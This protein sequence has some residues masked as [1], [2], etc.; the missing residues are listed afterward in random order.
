MSA[1]G[2]TLIKSRWAAIGAAVAVSLG[3][4][5]IGLTQAAVSSG[6]KPVFVPIE[7]CRLVDTR[8]SV[9]PRTAPLGA[10]EIFTQQITGSVGNCA[11]IP[12]EAVAAA[13]NVTS[14]QGTAQSF[15]TVYPGDAAAV[16]D[17]SNLNWRGGDPPKP[18]KVDVKLG[19]AGNV[20][21][22]NSVGTVHVAAD[23]VGYYIDHNHDDRYAPKLE[24][25]SGQ[26]E[27][28]YPADSSFMLVGDSYPQ[29]LP[30]GTDRPTIERVT[31]PT[32]TANCPA[33]GEAATAGV[34][35]VYEYNTSNINR[36]NHSGGSTGENRLYGFAFDVFP[37]N[38]ANSGYYLANWAYRVP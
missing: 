30:P 14:I 1:T 12:A 11:G 34:L 24:V 21:M 13:L 18:N 23:L 17:V 15:L 32:F 33:I 9:G 37:S 20:K 10:G 2:T 6:D 27:G 5:G 38:S 4:G 26:L 3:A 8:G 16:P 36:I 7:P 22:F 31:P 19:A 28:R 25:Y 35:C 29:P